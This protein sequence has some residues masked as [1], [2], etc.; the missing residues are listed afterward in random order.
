MQMQWIVSRPACLRC[1]L[2]LT[3]YIHEVEDGAVEF[4]LREFMD[5]YTGIQ[6]SIMHCGGPN[7]HVNFILRCSFRSP[8]RPTPSQSLTSD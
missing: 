3:A 4:R 7:N 6:H 2:Y 1:D 5:Q 8:Q